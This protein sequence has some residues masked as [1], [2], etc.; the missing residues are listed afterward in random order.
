MSLPITPLR[1]AAVY[2]M[3]RAWPPFC[4]WSL[5][6]SGELKFH[7]SKSRKNN[8]QWWIAGDRHH[9]EASQRNH[10]HLVTLILSMAHEMIHVRQ[11]VAR[12]ETPGVE[13]N[14][15]FVRIGKRIARRYGWDEGQFI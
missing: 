14:A 5:P 11:R 10:G 13:H 7:V 3:L 9:I 1:L 8:A 12:T 2:E 4:R 15:E 6:A